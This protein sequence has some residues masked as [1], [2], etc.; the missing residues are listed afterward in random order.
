[1]NQPIEML[2]KYWRYV[3]LIALSAVACKKDPKQLQYRWSKQ[4]GGLAQDYGQGIAVDSTENSYVTGVFSDSAKF[5]TVTLKSAGAQDIFLAKFDSTGELRWAIRTGG[6]NADEG[7]GLAVDASGN[8]GV[9]GSS[10]SKAS[11]REMT[12]MRAGS[13]DIFI[14][15]Y[16]N[17]GKLLWSKYAGGNEAD[18]G[19]AIAQDAAG[20]SYVTG[21]FQGEAV[22]GEGEPR[23]EIL[24]SAG[25]TDIFIAK[26]NTSGNLLWARKAG[27]ASA[28]TGFAVAVDA[29]G[30]C[31]VAGAF[32]DTAVFD[33]EAREAITVT[34]AGANDVFIA[35]YD[36]AGNLLWARS[37]GGSQLDQGKSLAVDARSN[38]YVTGKFSNFAV[39]E[40]DTLRGFEEDI[41][42]AK[43]NARGS[44]Q[45]VRSA[46]G[47][48]QDVGES[49]ALEDENSIHVSGEFSNEASFGKIK[50][51]C[52]AE[53]DIFVVQYDSLGNVVSARKCGTT[54][55]RPGV[56][57]AVTSSGRSLFTGSF[58]GETNFGE[59]T[60]RAG[61]GAD[62]FAAGTFA[63]GSVTE[64][65]AAA[66]SNTAILLKWKY[67]SAD[68]D[69][70]R[71]ERIFAGQVTQRFL[72]K[73][74]RY[75]LDT[76]LL[77]DTTYS[78]N[79]RP[80]INTVVTG[81]YT[82]V[83]AKTD[84][85]PSMAQHTQGLEVDN[86]GGGA[87]G[88]SYFKVSGKNL[89]YDGHLQIWTRLA[90]GDT[91][92]YDGDDGELRSRSE[93]KRHPYNGRVDEHMATT[94]TY[95]PIT[96]WCQMDSSRKESILVEQL[97]YQNIGKPL[98][99]AEWS[100]QNNDTTPRPVKV[101]LFLDVDADN[102]NLAKDQGGF[103]K[104][105]KL[106]YINSGNKRN[107]VGMALIADTSRFENYQISAFKDPR[108]PDNSAGSDLGE[109]ARKNL[110][111]G[112]NTGSLFQTAGD[113]SMTLISNLGTLAPKQS[114]KI[115]YAIAAAADLNSLNGL[116]DE[117]KSVSP[118]ACACFWADLNC[119]GDYDQKDI[120]ALRSHLPS[121]KGQSPDSALKRKAYDPRADLNY[122]LQTKKYCGNGK[123]DVS[124]LQTLM[125][126]IVP[127]QD[128]ASKIGNR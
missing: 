35:Q 1:M 18:R 29:L 45:W 47:R 125:W 31:F 101:A 126:F 10:Q 66:R 57:N 17:S 71:V 51:K 123:V 25:S 79:V 20:N 53:R 105:R 78:Y 124:D 55:I 15:R 107:Y 70:F 3:L 43:Y 96:M 56:R 87:D 72:P 97:T 103:D 38:C 67:N 16:D 22:F 122:N 77:P 100:V 8:I 89:L 117:A 98:V 40:N 13:D 118:C 104:S 34:S 119:D 58:T 115:T 39:F 73:Y 48:Q 108:T 76:G 88:W 36:S 52:E 113:L 6:L 12:A 50:L 86:R 44:L 128:Q 99:L 81:N 68:E 93:V 30:N 109:R 7:H 28:D 110:F 49:I 27:G 92:V 95:E 11:A 32:Q 26:Y 94:T 102:Q 46:G 75:Y 23:A 106:V 84:S 60:L 14:A 111:A 41:F 37:A 62:I 4:A 24:K 33:S 112:R 82:E 116:I 5:G 83:K 85:I 64:S 61:A 80:M 2:S 19:T 127:R 9:V 63:S 21:Y 121:L 65:W 59:N 69:S 90:N 42:V 114:V 54:G 120:E 91:M 74:S